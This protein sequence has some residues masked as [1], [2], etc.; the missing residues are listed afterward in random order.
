MLQSEETCRFATFGVHH[1]VVQVCLEAESLRV[2]LQNCPES[3][4]Q[5]Q[6]HLIAP[7]Q[8]LV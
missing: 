6:V 3:I 1:V 8:E 5:L 4:K 2:A 7:T